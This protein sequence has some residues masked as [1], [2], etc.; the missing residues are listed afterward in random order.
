[1]KLLETLM[2]E[3]DLFKSPF[4]FPLDKSRDKISTKLGSFL[5][6]MIISILI[7]VFFQSDFFLKQNPTT[8]SQNKAIS[9]S[10]KIE[11]NLK[12]FFFFKIHYETTIHN[13]N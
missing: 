9:Y 5:S 7:S 11:L 13:N 10:P 6:L 4:Y 8:L 3:L 2:Y 1:M 12:S